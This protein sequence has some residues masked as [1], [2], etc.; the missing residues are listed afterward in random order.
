MVSR[1]RPAEIRKNYSLLLEQQFD[2]RQFLS[3]RKCVGIYKNM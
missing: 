3:S 1:N 2:D